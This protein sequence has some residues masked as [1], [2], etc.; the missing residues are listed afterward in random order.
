MWAETSVIYWRIAKMVPG[1]HSCYFVEYLGILF[2]G[3]KKGI[4]DNILGV[5][6]P[7]CLGHDGPNLRASCPTCSFDTCTHFI[8]SAASVAALNVS[9]SGA[10]SHLGGHH[11]ECT[12]LS[13]ICEPSH[14][15]RSQNGD[16][17]QF[18]QIYQRSVSHRTVLGAK[19]ETCS[20]FRKFIRDLWA[21]AQF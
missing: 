6:Q 3:T 10:W 16:M 7:F 11:V 13:E 5:G 8:W 1:I 18:P 12:N 17:Q 14:S 4:S 21:I 15:F 2:G 9:P 19:T 20:N